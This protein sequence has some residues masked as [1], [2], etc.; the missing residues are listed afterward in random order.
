[1]AR[2]PL[3]NLKLSPLSELEPEQQRE[4]WK[5]AVST[6]LGGKVTAAHIKKV[7]MGME[8]TDQEVVKQAPENFVDNDSRNLSNIKTSWIACNASEKKKFIKWLSEYFAKYLKENVTWIKSL[9]KRKTQ[10][11]PRENN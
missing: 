10:K 1:M 7:M 6:A 9:L 8:K 3:L 11:A 5:E 2:F 4:V